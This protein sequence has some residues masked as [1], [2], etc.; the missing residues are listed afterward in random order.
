MVSSDDFIEQELNG[1]YE[2]V[3]YIC[4]HPFTFIYIYNQETRMSGLTFQEP[5]V[6][7]SCSLLDVFGSSRW[8]DDL[9]SRRASLIRPSR[10]ASAPGYSSINTYSWGGEETDCLSAPCQLLH[11]W[12]GINHL[13]NPQASL[14]AVATIYIPSVQ[15]A[16][17]GSAPQLP[18]ILFTF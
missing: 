12:T 6:C 13:N 4:S 3:P 2:D 10:L 16:D 5:P 14:C 18:S 17:Q 1:L 15:L 11:L 7:L 8:P 9:L